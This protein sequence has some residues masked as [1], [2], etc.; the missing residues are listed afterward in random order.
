[1]MSLLVAPE[2]KARHAERWPPE[3][4]YWSIIESRGHWRAGPLP[5][6]LLAEA[7][8][9]FPIDLDQLHAVG[10]TDSQAHLVV[11]AATLE[12]LANVPPHIVSLTPAAPPPGVDVDPSTLELLVGRFEPL[13][14]RRR[15]MRAHLHWAATVLG[16]AFLL[17]FGMVCRA[18]DAESQAARLSAAR[19]ALLDALDL[20][21]DQLAEEAAHR[22]ALAEALDQA[23]TDAVPI[24]GALLAAWPT[25]T[26]ASVEALTVAPG[27]ILASV[28]LT[29]DPASFLQ[30]LALPASWRMDEPRLHTA[31]GLSR[32]GLQ[33]HTEPTP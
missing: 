4:F 3:R 28:S 27:Q 2:S 10:V 21:E 25:S 7:A 15:R 11:C 19:G 12:S 17:A 8:D 24:L 22:R 1:M 20:P 13:T 9:D 29:S 23:P 18:T 30:T 33:I 6:G 5:P 31:R 14:W 16:C 32:L 26:D